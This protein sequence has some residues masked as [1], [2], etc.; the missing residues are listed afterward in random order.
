MPYGRKCGSELDTAARIR[1][2]VMGS[3]TAVFMCTVQTLAGIVVAGNNAVFGNSV[4]RHGLVHAAEKGL[5]VVD[6]GI[7]GPDQ[8]PSYGQNPSYARQGGFAQ[9]CLRQ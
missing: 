7:G 1:P 3:V 5:A 9:F 8:W 2:L 4:V 6:N